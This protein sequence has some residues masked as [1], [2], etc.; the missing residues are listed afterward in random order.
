MRGKW[1]IITGASSGIGAATARH[2]ARQGMDVLIVARRK[3][4]LDTLAASINTEKHG[5]VEVFTADLGK[6][7]E[8]QRLYERISAQPGGVDV[9]VNNAGIM[10]YGYAA[11]MSWVD[12]QEMV[13]VNIG[14]TVQLTLLCLPGMQARGRGHIINVGSVAG[15][16]PNQGVAV[17]SA[18]KAFLD[19]FTTSLHRELNGTGVH[20]SVVRPGPVT[21]EFFAQGEKRANTHA[22]RLESLSITPER[23]AEKIW[24]LTK[25]PRRAV[26]V[27]GVLI[28]AP[29]IEMFFG[30]LIDKVGPLLLRKS[31]A[32]V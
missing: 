6:S 28:L 7:A 13:A 31:S 12:A 30:W 19:A 17:Y 16:F 9:L 4:R 8:R 10:W 3:E 24:G 5:K 29:V 14:A 21:T 11:E 25:W 20:V 18:T 32:K 23:V 15:G 2:F 22:L 1:A 26:Y 27:P